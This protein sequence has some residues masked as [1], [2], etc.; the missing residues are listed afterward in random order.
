MDYDPFL[1]PEFSSS[2]G[3][4]KERYVDYDRYSDECISRLRRFNRLIAKGQLREVPEIPSKSHIKLRKLIAGATGKS[5]QLMFGA[6]P[7]LLEAPPCGTVICHPKIASIILPDVFSHFAG[8][9][10][11]QPFDTKVGAK[12]LIKSVLYSGHANAPRL[13]EISALLQAAA[14]GETPWNL[15]T[16]AERA[17]AYLNAQAKGG[18]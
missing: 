9:N 17:Q 4:F 6:C 3:T 11:G 18:K 2:M 10:F 15:V 14:C 5:V 7:M 16:D 8:R 1:D 12:V 13:A